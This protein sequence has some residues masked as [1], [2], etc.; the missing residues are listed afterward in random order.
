MISKSKAKFDAFYQ[1][2]LQGQ[3]L[4]PQD[5]KSLKIYLALIRKNP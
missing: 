5:K 2:F 1:S 4:L 3:F